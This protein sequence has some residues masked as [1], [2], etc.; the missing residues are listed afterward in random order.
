MS[1]VQ[2]LSECRIRWRLAS[3]DR[4]GAAQCLTVSRRT[5]IPKVLLVVLLV[6][7]LIPY[8]ADAQTAIE[9]W[10]IVRAG[11]ADRIILKTSVLPGDRMAGGA[12]FLDGRPFGVWDV[13]YLGSDNNGIIFGRRGNEFPDQDTLRRYEAIVRTLSA[14]GSSPAVRN[15]TL[16]TA[17]IMTALP[18]MPVQQ[19]RVPTPPTSIILRSLAQLRLLV[20]LA[21]RANEI[22]VSGAPV[23]DPFVPCR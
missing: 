20:R 18:N 15:N 11:H 16:M 22:L 1:L 3:A 23:E 7:V 6:A 17:L 13:T 19:F 21:I 9:C 5:L 10:E 12:Q 14:S 4:A 2:L 8:A